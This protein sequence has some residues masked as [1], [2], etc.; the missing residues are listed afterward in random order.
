MRAG[1]ATCDRR[2]RARRAAQ[3][4]AGLATVVVALSASDPGAA[5]PMHR[6]CTIRGT[7]GAD[8]LF[9]TPGPDVIC[10]FGGNDKLIGL[11]GNDVLVGGPGNDYLEGG[12]GRDV[13]LGGTGNDTFRSYDGTRDIVDGG[14]GVDSGWFDHLDI[15]RNVEH[16]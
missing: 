12:A 3:A 4:A 9:G 5:G 1:G 8:I 14:P 13:M 11:N 2:L 7:S 15:V 16:R 6:A 10:G